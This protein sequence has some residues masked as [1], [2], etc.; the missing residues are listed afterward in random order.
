MLESLHHTL[1]DIRHE[2]QDFTAEYQKVRG[3]MDMP[4]DQLKA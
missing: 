2:W 3:K 4:H 1:E